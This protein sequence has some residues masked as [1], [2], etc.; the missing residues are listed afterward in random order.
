[1]EKLCVLAAMVTRCNDD[2]CMY[3]MITLSHKPDTAERIACA[4]DVFTHCPLKYRP[5]VF[6]HGVCVRG[7]EFVSVSVL[8]IARLCVLVLCE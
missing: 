3:G 4:R 2:G 7:R 1:M 5:N 8:V 6:S